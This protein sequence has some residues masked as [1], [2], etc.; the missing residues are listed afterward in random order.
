MA[1]LDDDEDWALLDSVVDQHLKKQQNA[2]RNTQDSPPGVATGPAVPLVQDGMPSAHAPGQQQ[3]QQLQAAVP[4]PPQTAIVERQ[5]GQFPPSRPLQQQPHQ[6]HAS[7]YLAQHSN[8][9]PAPHTHLQQPQQQA[10]PGLL[11]EHAE[12]QAKVRQQEEQL[13]MMQ[14][15][16]ARVET[17]RKGLVERLRMLGQQQ[18]GLGAHS[19]QQLREELATTIQ[20]LRFKEEEGE[21][22]RRR[23]ADHRD[24]L[25]D[26]E[27]RNTQLEQE[28]R[29]GEEQR[30]Q[31]EAEL[32]AA[33]RDHRDRTAAGP[34]TSPQPAPT[35][36]SSGGGRQGQKRG[37]SAAMGAVLQ[38]LQV[39]LVEAPACRAALWGGND[40][41]QHPVS[42]AAD[43]KQPLSVDGQPLSRVRLKG[44]GTQPAQ[45]AP[46]LPCAAPVLSPAARSEKE[47]G[48]GMTAIL[49]ALAQ[50]ACKAHHAALAMGLLPVWSAVVQ[51]APPGPP[52]E[53]LASIFSTGAMEGLLAVA[54]GPQ[55]RAAC[56]LAWRLLKL[57]STLTLHPQG[58]LRAAFQVT[59]IQ[60]AGPWQHLP[61]GADLSTSSTARAGDS[62]LQSR[63]DVAQGS[64]HGDV[65]QLRLVVVQEALALL[66]ALLNHPSLGMKA[67]AALGGSMAGIQEVL[68]TSG[69]LMHWPSPT[70]AQLH[71]DPALPI[72][73]WAS[74]LGSSSQPGVAAA[75]A[76]AIVQF[77]KGLRRRLLQH[78]NT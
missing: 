6:P 60:E 59:P 35:R 62:R 73:G 14:T 65:W 38:V 75:S 19:L 31:M 74:A 44:D 78:L 52:T 64:G 63:P 32:A 48:S 16:M 18:Q 54:E 37:F 33:L 49:L 25:R 26:L 56:G 24:R 15:N 39:L 58:G 61:L 66:R 22:T 43:P 67:M 10:P 21:D 45:S 77:A 71:A 2:Q 42:S 17:E 53:H 46:A 76:N 12:L 1:D 5:M 8:L 27:T 13:R 36:P 4:R 28:V 57:A 30:I 70:P 69:R 34:H 51:A 68:T 50:Q 41:E 29:M 47:V 20:Q 55:G 23:A 40:K 9:S 11:A 7:T 3:Q 72:A